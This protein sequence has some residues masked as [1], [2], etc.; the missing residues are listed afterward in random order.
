MDLAFSSEQA[1]L[2]RT[3][4]QFA[5]RELA[6][7]SAQWDKTGEFPWEAWRRMGELGL[8]GLRVPVAHGGQEADFLTFGIAME[9][10]GRGDFSCTYAIQLAGLAGEILGR[11]APA[12]VQA[13]WLPP[14]ARGDTVVALALTEPGAGSDAANLACRAER[15][16]TDYVITG[17]KSGISLGMAAHAAIVFART[18]PSGRARGVT[19]FLVP[20]DLPGVSRSP[21]RDM[22]TRAIGRAVLAFDHVRVPA[23]HRLGE[24]GSGFRQLV[25]KLPQERLSLA[26]NAVAAARAAFGWT[27]EYCKERTAFGQPIGSFQHNRFKLAEMRTEIDLGQVFVDRQVEALNAGELTAEDAAEGKWWCTEMAWRTLDTCLQLH[28]GYGYMEEYPIARAWRDGRIPT[29]YGGTTEIMK[30]IIGRSLGV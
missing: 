28:G 16:S 24:E 19:A 1:E 26:V 13:R 11:S 5:R 9:E 4:R 12:E 14:T 6:P 8:L 15:D 21:L 7:R 20:L 30:E 27:L 10:I 18:D 29:I 17:E 3:L 2:A 22:G 25:T 23:S